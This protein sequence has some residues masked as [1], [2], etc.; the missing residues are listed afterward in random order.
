M[1]RAELSF[2]ILILTVALLFGACSALESFQKSDD[3]A[4][5][6]EILAKLYQEPVLKTRDIRV[7]SE[8]GVVVLTGTVGTESERAEAERLASQAKGV[9]Q[10]INQLT[11]SGVPALSTAP[12]A[13]ET[14]AQREAAPLAASNPGATREHA[15]PAVRHR[16]VRPSP[17]P[18]V[19]ST[20]RAEPFPS[21]QS[22]TAA[23][24]SP[25]AAPR[26][27]PEPVRITVP[28]GTVVTVR[29]ID[30]IDTSRNHAGD[31]F[32]ATVDSPVVVGERVVIPRN[33]EARLRLVESRSAGHISG[34]SELELELVKLEFGSSTYPVETSIHKQQGASRGKRTAET[35]GGGAGL[36]ALIGAIAGHGKG[37]A[38]GAAVGAGAGTAVQAATRGQ[39]V[40]IPSETKLDFTLRT[41]LTVMMKSE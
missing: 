34:R 7:V 28:A 39:Q 41:P 32:S 2:A 37:A 16:E 3:K 9:K 26:V 4:I 35:V 33:S 15:R 25:A 24:P 18:E 12:P 8:K 36:G 29:L 20:Q 19:A 13:P 14:P 10:V 17:A 23:A 22:A 27:P 38:I 1:R 11:M 21:S 40:R 6:S 5:T 31:E 30:S